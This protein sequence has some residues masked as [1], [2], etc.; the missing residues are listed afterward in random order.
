MISD[1]DIWASALLIL[2]QHGDDA[3]I[4][5]SVKADQMLDRGDMEGRAVWLRT[6]AAIRELLRREVEEGVVRH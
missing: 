2:K 4:E 3:V 6:V 1:R 5:T